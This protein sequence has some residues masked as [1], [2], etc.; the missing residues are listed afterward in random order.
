[1]NIFVCD[2]RGIVPPRGIRSRC[3]ISPFVFRKY[4]KVR[5]TECNLTLTA[6]SW[7]QIGSLV[8]VFIETTQTITL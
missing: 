2:N 6:I 4:Q 3:K 5:S 8:A 1:M 7:R